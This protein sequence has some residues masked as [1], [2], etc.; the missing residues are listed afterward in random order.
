MVVGTTPTCPYCPRAVLLAHQTAIASDW[1]TAD[2]IDATEFPDL[3][4]RYHV[5]G[6]PRTVIND[7]VHIE[8]AV[9]EPALMSQLIPLLEATASANA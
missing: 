9:P 3:A 7:A 5:H 6:V 8:G 1:V 2:A 4:D